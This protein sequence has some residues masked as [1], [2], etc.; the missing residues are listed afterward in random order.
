MRFNLGTLLAISGMAAASSQTATVTSIG[1]TRGA[2]RSANGGRTGANKA[3]Q[4]AAM[5]KR[6]IKA[7]R[8]HA[9]G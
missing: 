9:R 3:F 7:H 8:K 1:P 4:R 5:K 2:G 6:R